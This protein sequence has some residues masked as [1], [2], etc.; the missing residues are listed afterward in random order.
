MSPTPRQGTQDH[1]R[2]RGE[3]VDFHGS[4]ST[5]T[6]SSPLARGTP[7]RMEGTDKEQRIIPACAGN[8]PE[9]LSLSVA[10]EDHPRLRGEHHTLR[11]AIEP[12]LGSS[13]LARGTLPEPV[14]A[15]E[16][17]GIIPACAGNT[18]TRVHDDRFRRDHPRLRGE[19][20]TWT[21]SA[22]SAGG[23]SPLARGTPSSS[24]LT[25]S[26]NG[27]IPACAGNT[28]VPLRNVR[29]RRDHPRLRGEH[30]VNPVTPDT[31]VGSSP[32]AR[33]TR[34]TTSATSRRTRIIPACA[35]NTRW[36]C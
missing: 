36:R 28:S 9:W 20:T 4:P 18:V 15:E 22:R 29:R 17:R 31:V 14:V 16:R 23:S 26:G 3:H 24:S 13:P 7:F 27:I 10:S 11:G 6:G 5:T 8:T 1:P 33:G 35:G 2:L 12:R 21:T 32:L 19:H 25:S 30:V 34:M